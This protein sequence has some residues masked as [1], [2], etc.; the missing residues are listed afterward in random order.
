MKI[1]IEKGQSISHL[2]E[3][4]Q[5]F[6]P[7]LK[8]EFYNTEHKTGEATSKANT[9]AGHTLLESINPSIE[10]G[11]ITLTTQLTVSELELQFIQQFGLSAQVFH[12]SGA[13]WLQ[14]TRTDH[15]TLH[16]Q[17]K[18]AEEKEHPIEGSK[19]DAMDRQELE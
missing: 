10:K 9:I 4:F 3:Q 12:K 15:W 1:Y 16:E 18:H 19:I 17:N 5:N 13:V 11:E 7:Y 2:Q 14:T 6:F 8:I